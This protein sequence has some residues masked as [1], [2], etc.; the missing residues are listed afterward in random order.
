[1]GR[2]GSVRFVI[3]LSQLAPAAAS[4]CAAGISRDSARH[5]G[6]ADSVYATSTR[7]VRVTMG[8]RP[9]PHDLRTPWPGQAA[10]CY[11]QSC[12]G[13]TKQLGGGWQCQVFRH[14]NLTLRAEMPRFLPMKRAKDDSLAHAVA[15]RVKTGGDDRLWTYADFPGANRTALAAALS[16][17]V[18]AGELTRVRRGVYYRPKTTMFGMSR[19]DP[20]ALA[21]A[22][23]RARGEAPMP[24]GVSAFN[25]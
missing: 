19:P 23:L 11:R 21:D 22:I 8:S 6:A 12:H 14:K 13:A 2:S 25:R 18:K 16:R 4:R 15:T 9:L 17:L 24:A 7:Q 1:M 3:S 10:R 5:S 20:E